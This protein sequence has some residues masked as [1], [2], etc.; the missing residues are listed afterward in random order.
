[1]QEGAPSSTIADLYDSDAMPPDLLHAHR[2]LDLA[3]DK[4][5]RSEPFP[6]DRQRVEHLFMLCEKL[7]A[8]LTAQPRPRRRR[9]L[10]TP[11]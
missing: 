9:P 11:R 8:P 4:L 5:Y 7:V 6:S 3:V 2:A 10:D 1:V